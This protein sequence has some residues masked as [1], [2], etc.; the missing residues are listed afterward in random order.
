MINRRLSCCFLVFFLFFVVGGVSAE[1]I[2][3]VTPYEYLDKLAIEAG[4]DK[5]S[6]FHNYTRIYAKYFDSLRN[7]PIKFLEIG[8]Y[9]GSSVK[10]WESYFSKAE[11]HFV[12]INP[13]FIEYYSDRSHY[14]FF[15]QKDANK[16]TDF[17]K[18]TGGDFDIII[19]DGG[20]RMEEQI[21]S[22]EVL[23]HY[24]KS[25]G[26]YIIEDL[27]TSYWRGY[28][29]KGYI[30]K[31]L[32]GPGTCV[33]FLQHLIDDLN[34]TAGVNECADPNKVSLELKKRL[35]YYQD[36]I[37]SIHFYKSLCIII[38]K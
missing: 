16:L 19:D 18:L 9:K 28:G 36:K 31:P 25:G 23:F 26:M 22:F 34:Y 10:L 17:G 24:V 38:K 30:G 21:T 5:S 37:E 33:Y 8:I 20:H 15:D 27:H 12:D 11:L 1:N 14:H 29:G 3:T 32:S 4:A 2:Q 6:A 13:G 35:N 7:D